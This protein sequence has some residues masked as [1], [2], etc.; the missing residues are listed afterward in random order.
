MFLLLF[1]SHVQQAPSNVCW[2]RICREAGARVRFNALLR[3]MNVGVPAADNR[4]LEILAQD[5][6]C[7]GGAQLAV[8]VTLRGV[9]SSAGEPHPRAADI[10]GVILSEA[11][12]DKERRYPELWQAAGAGSLSLP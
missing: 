7:F 10:D 3:D 9:L 8:D 4:R 5:L 1:P 12:R 11:R 6:P 2:A